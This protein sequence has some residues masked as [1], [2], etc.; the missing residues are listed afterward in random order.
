MSVM[1]D[2]NSNKLVTKSNMLIEANYKL[3]V[4]ERKDNS[5]FGQ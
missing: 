2:A 3:G 1:V 4:V 5:L